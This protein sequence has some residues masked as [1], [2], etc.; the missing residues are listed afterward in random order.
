MIGASALDLG[1]HPAS[2]TPDRSKRA[3]AGWS[4]RESGGDNESRRARDSR[5]SESVLNTRCELGVLDTWCAAR[6]VPGVRLYSLPPS[7]PPVATLYEM[8]LGLGEI[9]MSRARDCFEPRGTVDGIFHTTR[10]ATNG[11]KRV[12]G[13]GV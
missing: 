13:P 8:K 11:R 9:G 12:G 10:S 7:L 1:P 5:E 4:V 6:G 3:V 2:R